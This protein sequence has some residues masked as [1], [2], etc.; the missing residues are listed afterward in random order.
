M[1]ISDSISTLPFTHYQ[2]ATFFSAI[3]FVSLPVPPNITLKDINFMSD[4]LELL[5]NFTTCNFTT[6]NFTTTQVQHGTSSF[7]LLISGSFNNHCDITYGRR[8][9][10]LP[11]GETPFK[12][13]SNGDSALYPRNRMTQLA[14]F[15]GDRRM[16][17]MYKTVRCFFSGSHFFACAL[18]LLTRG[19]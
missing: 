15:W 4:T 12:G 7:Y 16:I 13:I 19:G 6:C 14:I 18:I 1:V 3:E 10:L 5:P 2:Y 9:P 17:L 8:P 11:I